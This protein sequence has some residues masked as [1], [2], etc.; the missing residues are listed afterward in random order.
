MLFLLNFCLFFFLF[1]FSPTPYS[2][3]IYDELNDEKIVLTDEELSII[4][5]IRH[6]KFPHR[7]FDPEED[8]TAPMEIRVERLGNEF[9]SKARFIPSKHE[10]KIVAKLSHAIRNGWIRPKKVIEEETEDSFDI[11]EGEEIRNKNRDYLPAPKTILPGHAESYNPPSEYLLTE[12]ERQYQESL[13]PEDR[14]YDFIPTKNDNLRTVPAYS[15]AVSERF[16]R[17]LDLYL[18]VRQRRQRKLDINPDSLIPQLPKPKDLKPFPTTISLEYIGH[19]NSVRC[20]DVDPTGQWLVSGSEDCTVRLWEVSTSRCV[21]VWNMY[22]AVVSVSFNPNPE[23]PIIA[24]A[25]S[26]GI[27]IL[28]TGTGS[29]QDGAAV[30]KMLRS[31]PVHYRKSRQ[32]DGTLLEVVAD[33]VSGRGQ[34]MSKQ[35]QRAKQ[36]EKISSWVSWW[37]R[38]KTDEM[39]ENEELEKLQIA[40]KKEKELEKAARKRT[41]ADVIEEIGNDEEEK[42]ENDEEYDTTSGLARLFIR[43][44]AGVTNIAWHGRGDYIASVSPVSTSTAVLIH[45]ISNAATQLPFSNAKGLVQ[46]VSFHPTKPYFLVATQRHVKI[47][48]LATQKHVRTLQCSTKF[49]SSIDIHPSGEHVLVGGYDRRVSWFDLDLSSQPYRTLKYH[50]KAVRS[51]AFH[52][53]FPL[54]A[55]ASDDGALHIIHCTVYD[56][57]LT[58]PL[59][60]PVK[61]INA[62]IPVSDVGALQCVF[63]PIQPWVFS[64]AADHSIRLFC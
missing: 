27:A 11:W 50:Q 59:L 40:A 17:M 41:I 6:G 9:E 35:I 16:N 63:H 53:K 26:T 33:A 56:D 36:L 47:Y 28:H 25:L 37:N 57:L 7:E 10:A 58:N 13:D 61:I 14:Q 62:H 20:M 39:L 12:E 21:R 29:P 22:E 19:T 30:E 4:N 55:S 23:L 3:T 18:S 34:G 45:R 52:K 46:K 64:C 8:Y 15:N 51:V 54:F 48:N 1:L 44:D 38:T 60:V 32:T 43:V 5:R 2:R 31:A 24:A 42:F 49:I